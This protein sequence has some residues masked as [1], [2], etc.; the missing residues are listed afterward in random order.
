[1][2]YS[3]PSV[4]EV[5]VVGANDSYR[6]ETVKAVVS[7]KPAPASAEDIQT[8]CR[9][10]LAAYKV[11]RI[12]AFMDELPKNAGGKILRRELRD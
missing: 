10:K 3:H 9:D 5:A 7:L 2:I 6:G 12:V 11:P 4:R 8:L 1:M